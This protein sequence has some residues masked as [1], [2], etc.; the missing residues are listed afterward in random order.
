LSDIYYSESFATPIAGPRTP[1]MERGSRFLWE[2]HC[3]RKDK[4]MFI[5]ALDTLAK[6]IEQT[7]TLSLLTDG[8]RRLWQLTV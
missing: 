4:Q 7:N 1:L 5:T 2:L 6:V 3:G 8:E